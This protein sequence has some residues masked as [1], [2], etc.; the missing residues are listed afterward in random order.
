ME[1]LEMMPIRTR[2]TSILRKAIFSGEYECGQELSL[3]AVAE[4][5][6]VSRTPVREA[7]QALESEGLITLRMNRG[8]IVNKID[9]KFIKDIFDMRMMLESE[10]AWRA[11]GNGLDC[12]ELLARLE[13][14]KDQPVIDKTAYEQLNQDIHM[15]IWKAA[16]NHRLLSYLM[17]L[18]NGPSTSN[19]FAEIQNHYK[20][21][22]V[23][24]IALLRAIQDQDAQAARH[25]MYDHILRSRDNI[26]NAMRK[27]VE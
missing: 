8:A 6:G 20:K 21:S 14:I 15:S 12:K 26:L 19:S 4:Q 10:A 11:A 25:I 2:I 24:H 22:T 18:W 13:G 7:F 5:L 9:E 1:S 17:E 3:T 27:T 23:E 16:D